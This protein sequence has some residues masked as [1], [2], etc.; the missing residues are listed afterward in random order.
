MKEKSRCAWVSD[1][2]LYIDYHDREWGVPERDSRALWEKLILD[3]F[4]AGLSWITILRKRE[5]F[6]RA[7]AEF[8]PEK[9]SASARVTSRASWPTPASYATAPR[10]K[11]PSATRARSSSSTTASS[12]ASAGRSST[13]RRAT[14]PSRRAAKSPPRPPNRRRSQG[15]GGARL[16]LRRPDDRLRLDAGVRPRQR[17]PHQL[18]PLQRSRATARLSAS[19]AQAPR[20]R[21]HDEIARR[22]CPLRPGQAHF[23]SIA[24]DPVNQVDVLGA[25]QSRRVDEAL[26]HHHARD[27]TRHVRMLAQAD[28][29]DVIARLR[30]ISPW[31]C[32]SCHSSA[33]RVHS[34]AGVTRF[35]SRRRTRPKPESTTLC[36]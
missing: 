13:A 17:S 15:A 12:R 33:A 22:H 6:R 31:V 2:P 10:S 34:V 1:D 21:A 18:L 35:T 4:Q 3:G 28:D 8:D 7:F 32:S 16:P 29:D 9:S 5:N 23:E 36:T 24:V 26:G 30:R 20:D 11:P 19:K 14:T 25:R 27:R